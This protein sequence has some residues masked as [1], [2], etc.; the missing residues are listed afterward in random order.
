[1]TSLAGGVTGGGPGSLADL[2]PVPTECAERYDDLRSQVAARVD[3]ALFRRPDLGVLLGD[4]SP[5]VVRELHRYMGAFFSSV[6]RLGVGEILM[7]GLPR[8]LAGY[9]SRGMAPEYFHALPALWRDA[10]EDQLGSRARPLTAVLDWLDAH[11]E[12]WLPGEGG[13]GTGADRDE[14]LALVDSLLGSDY[15]AAQQRLRQAMSDGATLAD[16]F[17]DLVQPALYEVGF[18]WETGRI[19]AAQEHL[20]SAMVSRLL[21]SLSDGAETGSGRLAVVTT[22]PTE[23]HEFGAWMVADILRGSGWEVRFLGSQLPTAEILHFLRSVKP[24][25]LACSVTLEVHLPSM[26]E[27]VEGIRSDEALSSLPV[28]VGGQ[29][30]SG[31][32]SVWRATGADALAGDARSVVETANALLARS[33]TEALN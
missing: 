24:Q 1:M 18:A 20:A 23:T 16:V 28:L 14:V 17:V 29:A 8:V 3:A 31:G 30:F 10:L 13:T 2:L 12:R 5:S 32:E 25:L 15:P 33:A 6:F 21:A 22:A 9:R 26:R 11:R 19:T 7:D 4:A 27:L